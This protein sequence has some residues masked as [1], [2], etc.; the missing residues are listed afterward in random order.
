LR[1]ETFFFSKKEK[2]LARQRGRGGAKECRLSSMK[3]KR[4]FH[5]YLGR[6]KRGRRGA[7]KQ[8]EERAPL[9]SKKKRREKRLIFVHQKKKKKREAKKKGVIGGE[10]RGRPLSQEKGGSKGR[11]LEGRRGR[12]R[13]GGFL[14]ML[15]GKGKI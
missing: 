11:C 4:W 12:E 7:K 5:A 8:K 13:R 10:K 1:G 15:K 2:K 14:S 3:G 9:I 6:E